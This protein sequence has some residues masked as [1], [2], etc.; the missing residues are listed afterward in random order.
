MKQKI[1]EVTRK[2]TLT[3]TIYIIANNQ[4]E[5]IQ[6]SHNEVDAVSVEFGD[7]ETWS[8]DSSEVENVRAYKAKATDYKSHFV[9]DE[10]TDLEN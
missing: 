3:D 7:I 9:N 5:A 8:T 10:E 2:L 1:Y 6:K 4:K